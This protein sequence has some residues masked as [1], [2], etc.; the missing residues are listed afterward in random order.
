MSL[1]HPNLHTHSFSHPLTHSPTHPLTNSLTL[2]F[3]H[4]HTLTQ[5][6][7]HKPPPLHS[8]NTCHTPPPIHS[9]ANRTAGV[10]WRQT[11]GQRV[12]RGRAEG[13]VGQVLRRRHQSKEEAAAGAGQG[14]EE[15][16]GACFVFKSVRRVCKECAKRKRESLVWC[17]SCES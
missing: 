17:G 9:T 3:T 12:D 15:D 8:T 5:Q 1:T 16:E 10:H 13:R 4:T 11:S 14:Q 7:T 6:P 2:S